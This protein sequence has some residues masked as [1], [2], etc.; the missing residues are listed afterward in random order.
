[1]SAVKSALSPK[2]EPASPGLN[3][4]NL[5]SG[6]MKKN[7]DSG[8]DELSHAFARAHEA[9]ASG[10]APGQINKLAAIEERTE[11]RYEEIELVARSQLI[12]A[13]WDCGAVWKKYTDPL[14]HMRVSAERKSRTENLEAIKALMQVTREEINK[15]DEAEIAKKRVV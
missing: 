10:I 6:I 11:L 3:F 5:F 13:R 1:M 9:V 8:S 4:S 7:D 12:A 14:L 15:K 2:K